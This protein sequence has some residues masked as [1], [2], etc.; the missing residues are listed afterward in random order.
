L[1]KKA[2]SDVEKIKKNKKKP[3][4]NTALPHIPPQKPTHKS[5]TAAVRRQCKRS[6]KAK[7]KTLW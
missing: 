3:A 7:E 4:A 5:P 1:T 2:K 6:V